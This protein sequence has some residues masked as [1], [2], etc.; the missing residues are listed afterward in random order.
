VIWRVRDRSTFVDMRRRG[1]RSAD[2]PLVVSYL[3]PDQDARVGAPPR[4]A[5]A[6]GRKVGSAVERN[7]LRRRL[8]GLF[9]ELASSGVT[10]A[11]AYLVVVRPGAAGSTSTQLRTWLERCLAGIEHRD[12]GA[13]S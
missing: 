12:R 4:E 3:P 6:V 13:T 9:R 8:R 7:V 11:G 1:L 5:F 10:R 2:G